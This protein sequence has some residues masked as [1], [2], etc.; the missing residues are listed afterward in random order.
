VKRQR[1]VAYVTREREGRTELL[2]FEDPVHPQMGVQVPAGRLDP[3]EELEAGVLR[4]L[5][6]ESGL[7]AVRIVRE[8][9]GFEEHYASRYENHGFLIALEDDAPDEWQHLV[10]G[11][12]DDAGFVFHYR[13]VPVEPNVRLFHRVHPLLH[14]LAES[15]EREEP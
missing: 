10:V 5:G 12:G 8:L 6:E 1:V 7:T 4:E 13:W 9:P 2:V 14:R 15:A 3:G 11:D